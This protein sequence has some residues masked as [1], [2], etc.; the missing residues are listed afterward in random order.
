MSQGVLVKRVCR[1]SSLLL[2]LLLC[3][4]CNK[5]TDNPF[6]AQAL[7]PWCIVDFDALDRTPAQRIAMLKKMGFKRYGYDKGKGDLSTMHEEFRLAHEN[8]IEITSIFLWLNAKR[9]SIGKLSTNNRELLHNIS[10]ASPKPVIWLSFSPNFFE[11]LSQEQSIALAVDMVRYVKSEA[12][13]IG[14]KL[15][16]YNH[17][18]W[19]GNPY[20]QV[21]ILK[22]FSPNSISLVYNFHH[23]HEYVDGFPAIVETI[24]PYLSYV[25][26][27]GVKREG[28]KIMDIGAGDY[29]FEMIQVL[30][31]EGYQGPWGI[32]GH[33]KT[34][35]VEKV[36]E[37]NLAGLAQF[38]SKN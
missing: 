24:K 37:R 23:A 30:L 5:Q 17:H 11:E 10:H 12:D 29:E 6:E 25:N 13:K 9:D 14:C 1:L 18:G 22:E 3:Y 26:I 4:S 2:V 32:L 35:D 38:P 27:S 31:D 28:P 16:L 21:E 34:E 33:L 20:N 36:L 8:G 15:A 19:F 7:S